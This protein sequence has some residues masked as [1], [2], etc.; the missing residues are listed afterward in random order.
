MCGI[1]RLHE[2]V[3]TKFLSLSSDI[4][5]S[6][7][8]QREMNSERANSRTHFHDSNRNLDLPANYVTNLKV[9]LAGNK[10]QKLSSKF[11]EYVG[12]SNLAASSTVIN[13]LSRASSVPTLLL[14]PL[15]N[16][17]TTNQA[18][19][20]DQLTSNQSASQ[21]Q[22]HSSEG[23]SNNMSVDLD[24]DLDKQNQAHGESK[25]YIVS[26]ISSKKGVIL[27]PNELKQ[28]NA[29]IIKALTDY[30]LAHEDC[31]F[32]F[33]AN[34]TYDFTA[35]IANFCCGSKDT[36]IWLRDFVKTGIKFSKALATSVTNQVVNVVKLRFF[37]PNDEMTADL[38]KN[39]FKVSNRGLD[40]KSW[41]VINSSDAGEEQS[42]IID[43]D[44]KSYDFIADKGFRLDFG[45]QCGIKVKELT[46]NRAN[47]HGA[48]L[49]GK[50]KF[51]E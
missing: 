30:K 37:I 45:T 24:S 31:D 17:F 50:R 19:V 46:R 47:K 27:D 33:A 35:G 39:V 11:E 5:Q 49:F 16:Q 48:K 43:I 23:D 1:T 51:A 36:A 28:V 44:Q 12:G 15:E 26:V 41:E 13:S 42:L 14:R 22:M 8:D 4:S 29:L 40:T 34:T 9:Q 7:G 6:A 2:G 18:Q 21:D 20:K 10:K 3:K 38:I 25:A 32:K